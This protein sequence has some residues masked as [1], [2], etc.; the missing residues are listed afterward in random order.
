MKFLECHPRK[1]W[2]IWGQ[3]TGFHPGILWRKGVLFLSDT[4]DSSEGEGGCFP[5]AIIL[6]WRTGKQFLEST[7][8]TL[9]GQ[10]DCL[11]CQHQILKRVIT[12]LQCLLEILE[13]KKDVTR[14]PTPNHLVDTEAVSRGDRRQCWTTLRPN[15]EFRPYFFRR[16]GITFVV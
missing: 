16:K 15:I 14:M 13:H 6:S 10:G 7:I 8:D 3:I 1:F 5:G 2:R 11:V 12:F 4:L 9:L